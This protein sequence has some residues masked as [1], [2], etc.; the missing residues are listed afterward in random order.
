MK[1]RISYDAEAAQFKTFT[2]DLRAVFAPHSPFWIDTER[3]T[4]FLPE[5]FK[6]SMNRKGYPRVNEF[7]NSYCAQTNTWKCVRCF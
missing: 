7:K 5:P 1:Y 6:V 3:D 4:K 2:F